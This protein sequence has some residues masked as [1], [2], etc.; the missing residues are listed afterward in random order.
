MDACIGVLLALIVVETHD[1]FQSLPLV[2]AYLTLM[3]T[4]IGMALISYRFNVF[5]PISVGTLV[6]CMAGAAIDYPKPF[7]PYLAMILWT[8]NLLGFFATSLK[9]CSW[10]RWIVL[11]VSMTSVIVKVIAV[12]PT[13]AGCSVRILASSSS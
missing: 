2:P 7:F 5:I 6:M 4:G 12:M 3:A 10:L 9:R 8:A 11:A 1:R 13:T